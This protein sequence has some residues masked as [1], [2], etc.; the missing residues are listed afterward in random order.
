[1][2]KVYMTWMRRWQTHR[3]LKLTLQVGK[4]PLVSHT[5]L[6]NLQQ[7]SVGLC[8]SISV[9][10][11][12]ACMRPLHVFTTSMVSD[13]QSD[14]IQYERNSDRRLPFTKPYGP[15][16]HYSACSYTFNFS[17]FFWQSWHN[18][19]AMT[20]HESKGRKRWSIVRQ[21]PRI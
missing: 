1:M 13:C 6:Y 2:E 20:L 4:G 14:L 17:R 7:R 21:T 9:K 3:K 11:Y 8:A 10:T 12:S 5:V 19:R 15:H 16:A 18:K